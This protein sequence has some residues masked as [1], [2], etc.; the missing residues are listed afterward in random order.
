MSTQLLLGGS[1]HTPANPDATAMAVTDGTVVWVGYDDVGRRMHPGADIVDLDGRFVGPGF[2]DSHVHL[3]ATGLADAGLDLGASRSRADLLARLTAYVGGQPADAVVWA[4]GWDESRWEGVEA[5]Q[6][7]PPVLAE[8]DA[9]V[10]GRPAYLVRVDEHSALA[11]T[12]LRDKVADLAAA[13]GF[14]HTGPLTRDAHHGVRR[15]AQSLLSA[16]QRAEAHHRALRDIAALGVVAVHENGGPQI[17]GLDDFREVLATDTGIE[18]HGLWGEAARDTDHARELLATSGAAGLAGDLFVDGALGSRTAWLNEPY[19]DQPD[20]TGAVYLDTDA[21][22]A[23]LRALTDLRRQAGFHVIGDA[24]MGAVTDALARLAG[25]VGTPALAACAHRVEHAE[26]VTAEQREILARCGVIA[27]MQPLFDARWG[28]TGQMYEQRLGADRAATMND[29]AA[30]AKDG[31]ALA[32][33]SDSP[34]TPVSPWATIGAAVGHHRRE[35]AVSA[36]AAY[37]ACTRGGWRAAGRNDGLSGVLMP[38]APAS[39]AVF[40]ADTLVVAGSDDKV[41]RWSTDPRSRVPALP[42]VAPGAPIPTCVRTVHRG[43]VLYDSGALRA[44]AEIA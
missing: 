23:H 40:D 3:T 27:V 7:L 10:G 32:F 4:H 28:G 17:A 34:V 26:M 36:R 38:G 21:V 35:S 39:Y 42:D 5:D 13:A 24:A 31:V 16:T 33:S 6:C 37:N 41:Q 1:I 15:A 11:S 22:Y 25:E 44:T 8:I 12:A 43:A 20:V 2:V 18:I 14:S 19:A 30:L 9:A 29:F